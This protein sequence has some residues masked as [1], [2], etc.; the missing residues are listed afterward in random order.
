MK[1]FSLNTRIGLVAIYLRKKLDDKLMVLIERGSGES[2]WEGAP[3]QLGQERT[4]FLVSDVRTRFFDLGPRAV[5]RFDA[6]VD[7]LVVRALRY[8]L[9]LNP[10]RLSVQDIGGG[11]YAIL[12]PVIPT[13]NPD[14]SITGVD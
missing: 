4:K 14:G 9:C 3:A 8:Q 6:L 2:R 1:H 5:S 7:K 10:Q 13:L 12:V 11:H